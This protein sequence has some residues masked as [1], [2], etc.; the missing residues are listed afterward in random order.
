[1]ALVEAFLFIY[2]LQDFDG[3]PNVLIG[4][5]VTVMCGF[6]VPV[7]KW[8]HVAAG[9]ERPLLSLRSV[10]LL[11][12]FIFALRC[13]LYGLLPSQHP[14]LVLLVEPLHGLTFAAMWN[15]AVEYGK[16]LAAPGQEATMQAFI[17]GFYYQLADGLGSILWGHLTERPP[18]GLGMRTCY[19]INAGVVLIWSALWS[20]GWAVHR[21]LRQ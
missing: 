4:M 20:A 12:H 5:A 17:G 21:R 6:E 18:Q 13:V 10:L 9:G 8:F 15:A 14:W 11:C 7:F 16:R 3:T 19:F 2:L 1:M